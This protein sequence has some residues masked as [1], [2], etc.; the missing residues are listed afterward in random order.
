M[1]R[2]WEW[3][4]IRSSGCCV[5]HKENDSNSLIWAKKKLD[6]ILN[7]RIG[8]PRQFSKKKMEI[9]WIER[10]APVCGA[11]YKLRSRIFRQ[12]YEEEEAAIQQIFPLNVG[13]CSCPFVHVFGAI[14]VW[15]G[16]KIYF[17]YHVQY[18]P[19]NRALDDFSRTLNRYKYKSSM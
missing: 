11:S 13:S 1:L 10:K 15:H 19:W 5:T 16:T 2:Y 14:R 9:V 17:A 3:S 12:L 7:I 18:F 8:N 4:S 6:K